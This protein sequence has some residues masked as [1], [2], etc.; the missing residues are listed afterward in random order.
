MNEEY[1]KASAEA[2]GLEYNKHGKPIFRGRRWQPDINAN[3]REIIE[4]WLIKQECQMISLDWDIAFKLWTAYIARIE[5]EIGIQISDK[6]KSIAFMKAF[7]DYWQSQI[8]DK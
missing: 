7:M 5:W 3:H 8:N 1:R 2:L 6:S 4:D